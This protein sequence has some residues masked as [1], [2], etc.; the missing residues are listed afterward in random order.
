MSHQ[1]SLLI[2]G[3]RPSAA[4]GESACQG[5]VPA[6]ERERL[7]AELLRRIVAREEERQYLRRTPR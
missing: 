1:G 7:R 2:G 5:I 4:R 6:G 3:V